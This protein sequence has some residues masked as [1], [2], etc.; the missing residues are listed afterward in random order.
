MKQLTSLISIIF[1]IQSLVAQND[2]ES[3]EKPNYNIQKTTDGITID[4]HLNEGV[5][6][7][8]EVGSDFWVQSPVDDIPANKKTTFQ[9]TYDDKFVY[10]GI[11]CYDSEDYVIQ[12]LKRD[13]FGDS[14]DIGVFFD[15]LNQQSLCYAFG[16]NALGAQSEALITQNGG[17]ES[18]DNK[19]FSAVQQNEDHWSAEFAIP[20]KTLRFKTGVQEWGI[21]IV[22]IEPDANESHTWSRVPRQFEA[23]DLGYFGTLNWDVAPTKT[24]TNISLIPYATTSLSQDFDPDKKNGDFKIGG[25]AKIAITPSLNLDLTANPDF[26]QVEV[27]RQVTNL[28]RFNIFFPERRQFF[29]ENADIFNDFGQFADRPFYSRR[30]GLDGSGRTV[31]ILFGAR[32]SGNL[33][34]NLRAGFFNMHTQSNDDQAGQNYTAVAFQQRVFKRSAIKGLFLNRQGFDGSESIGGDYGR[35]AGGEFFYSTEDGKVSFQVGGIKSMKD[36]ISNKNQHLYGRFNYAGQNFRTFLSVQHLSENYFADMG[37]NGRLVNYN[38]ETNEFVRI[39]Y[40]QVSNMLDYYYYP[41]D[42]KKVNFHWS[43]LENFVW[44][45]T[46]GSV[47]EWYTR[48]RHFIFFKNTSQLRFRLNNIY[49]DLIFPFALTEN[50]LPKGEYNQREANIQ[51][52]TDQRKLV[53]LESFIVYGTFFGGKKLTYRG[54]LNFR[55]QPWG[56][57]ALGIE[58]NDIWL[59]E[60]FGD[61]HLTLAS[62]RVEINFSTNLFWTTFLQFNTQSDNFNINSRL[63]WRFAPMSDL[64]LVYTDNYL[65]DGKFGPKSRAVVLKANYWLTL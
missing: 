53:N 54:T 23:I 13:Q 42:S 25:D 2:L 20:F 47:N 29:L 4:G 33:N 51:F 11:K 58:Q 65:I 37:F 15:P 45:N 9:L 12:S 40:T 61:L 36:S 60:E 46:D 43:G 55:K 7:T 16:V 57:F 10:V 50:P 1:L 17:D 19:W 27:D 62:A 28:S 6:K 18:W 34:K 21:Q 44:F 64:Y 56:N 24:G 63:Q 14:D 5:W 52:N 26:S 41:T 8:A 30:I 31:P 22:R 32:L 35:N 39:A 59:P 38:P 49:T 3:F 48:L